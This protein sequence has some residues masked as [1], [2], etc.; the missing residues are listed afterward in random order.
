MTP[1]ERRLHPVSILFS[2]WKSLKAF[3]V[4]GLFLLLGVRSSGAARGPFGFLP[5]NWDAW[6]MWFLIPITAI[7]VVRYLTFRMRY[8]G[9]E[10][11]IRSGLLFRN[12]RHI[13]YDRIQNI[14]A[15]RSVFHRLLGMTDV[16]I[17]TA[18]GQRAE[19]TISV[20][21]LAV[22]DEMRRRVFGARAEAVGSSV[23]GSDPLSLGVSR[24]QTPDQDTDSVAPQSSIT[25]Q[26]ILRIPVRELALL[27]VIQNKG[28][29]PI[30]AG[31]GLLWEFGVLEGA[32]DTLGLERFFS[33]GALRQLAEAFMNRA[34]E[35][36]QV[37]GA[38]ATMLGALVLVQTLS[39]VWVVARLHGFVLTRAGEDLR[40]DYGLLTRVATTIP[41]RRIQTL[42]IQQGLL[43]RLTGRASVRV[44]TAGGGSV[45]T[46]GMSVRFGEG[47]DSDGGD[48]RWLAPIVRET[49]APALAHSVLPEFDAR[50]LAWNP[51]H[52]RAFRRAVKP[53]QLLSLIPFPIAVALREPWVL[54]AFPVVLGWV[55]YSTHKRIAHAA[56][57]ETDEIVAF[58]SGWIRQRVTAVRTAKIQAVTLLESPFDRRALMR[59]VRVDTAGASERSDRV[60]IPYLSREVADDLY[61]RLTARAAS[62]EF[63]W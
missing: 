54:I 36:W 47:S 63:R 56:W 52:P 26:A 51:L 22:L 34:L 37:T 3:A 53:A 57:A 43:Q 59:R 1:S 42:T 39:F 12:E 19:A 23:Q 4:P 27:S 6:A 49:D 21:P 44:E 25:E 35:S 33:G 14:N 41:L 30:A 15:I 5:A 20:V 9:A 32:A 16:Q 62:T 2:L 7:A 50:E 8:E 31:M 17:E 28:L 29:L 11:V 46:G 60:D 45:P 61:R 10:L 48:R 24:G 13:P 58:R 38:L 55:A 18:S 40:T